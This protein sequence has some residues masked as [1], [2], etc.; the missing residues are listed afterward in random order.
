MHIDPGRM[1][2]NLDS[3][4]TMG[5]GRISMKAAATELAVSIVE[6]LLTEGSD[7]LNPIKH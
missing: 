5:V 6:W 3:K 2:W 1:S 4:M 7:S